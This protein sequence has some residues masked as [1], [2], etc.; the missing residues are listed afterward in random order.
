MEG[1]NNQGE[2]STRQLQQLLPP[3]THHSDSETNPHTPSPP[4]GG[5]PSPNRRPRGRPPGSKNKPKHPIVITRDIPNALRSHVLEVSP[6]ADIME[7]LNNYARR[8]G[9]GVCVLS[10][11]GTVSNV[12]IREPTSSSGSVVTLQGGFDILSLTGTVLP[13]PAPRGAGGLSVFLSGGQ[14]QVLGGI[15]VAPL[16]ATS[17]IL[18]M[19]ASFT[20]AEFERL[21]SE[22]D[23]EAV[24][25]ED[26]GVGGGEVQQVQPLTGSVVGASV[27]L[28]SVG[29]PNYPFSAGEFFGLGGS[30][31]TGPRPPF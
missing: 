4:R 27:P 7:T 26:G 31:A 1:F 2:N 20:N 16:I 23:Q 17:T 14:G 13:P 24:A 21:P 6:G 19:A 5:G 15:V 3:P 9:R 30:N 10:G 8:R 12:I 22:E 18:L 28:F 25:Q 11:T 29:P